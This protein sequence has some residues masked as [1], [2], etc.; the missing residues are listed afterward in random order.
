MALQGLDPTRF[1]MAVRTCAFWNRVAGTG[2]AL[3][4]GILYGTRH[5][6]HVLIAFVVV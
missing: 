4:N 6:L 5:M 1:N 3:L 2:H